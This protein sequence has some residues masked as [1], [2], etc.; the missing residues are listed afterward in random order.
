MF[1]SRMTETFNDDVHTVFSYTSVA[2]IESGMGLFVNEFMIGY[3]S[4]QDV[5]VATFKKT[6]DDIGF[7]GFNATDNIYDVMTM[8]GH[9][10]GSHW[11]DPWIETQ[12]YMKG[13]NWTPQGNMTA[14]EEEMNTQINTVE[15]LWGILTTSSGI[16]IDDNLMD[17][18]TAMFKVWTWE[19]FQTTL[20]S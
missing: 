20:N 14:G 18:V 15:S 11:V 12:F 7:S 9:F 19:D 3:T 5:E 10:H 17:C 2:D 1:Y 6:L 13:Y 16:I 8:L 4:L